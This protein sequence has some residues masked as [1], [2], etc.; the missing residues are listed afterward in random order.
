MLELFRKYRTPLLSAG[1]VL[2]ALLLYSAHLKTRATT[3]LFERGVLQ[4]TAPVQERIDAAWKGL[5]YRWEHYLWLVEAER[6]NGL[7]RAENSRLQADLSE[8]QEVRL[9]NDRLRLLLDFRERT[10]LPVLPAQIIGEDASSWFRTVVIDKGSEDGLRENLP[11]VVA[12]GVV[13]RVVK[14]A[15]RQA[16]V[17]LIADASSAVAS[18]IQRTR[19]RGVSRGRGDTLV[20]DYALREDPVVEGDLIITSG[21]GGVFPKGLPIGRVAKVAREEYGLFQ[22]VTVIPA[23]DFTRLEEVL[24]LLR[25]D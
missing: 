17:L 12:E 3:T 15:P 9:A 19:T 21:T 22:Q 6:E 1:L 16:R 24:I 25:E 5:V 10:D 14:V 18:L 13:G 23:V 4:L 7:L 2:L 20:L 8:L 11:V